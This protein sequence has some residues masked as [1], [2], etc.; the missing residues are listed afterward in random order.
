MTP[1]RQNQQTFNG[2]NEN[3]NEKNAGNNTSTTT[4]VTTTPAM[5]QLRSN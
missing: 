2:L 5:T 4:Y 3:R 1:N